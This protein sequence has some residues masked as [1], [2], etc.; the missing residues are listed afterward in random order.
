MPLVR[1]DIMEGRPP[2]QIR[3]LHE[4]VAAVVA[5]ILQTPIERVRTYVT[6]FPPQAWGIGGI[7]ADVARANEVAARA[8]SANAT[9]GAGA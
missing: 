5:E 4:R 6:Q 9:D 2:E 7:P 8:A 1:I 3:A